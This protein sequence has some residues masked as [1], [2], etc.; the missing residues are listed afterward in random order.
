[1]ELKNSPLHDVCLSGG[2]VLSWRLSVYGGNYPGPNGPG[3]HVTH[4]PDGGGRDASKV[5]ERNE[6]LI[7]GDFSA[8]FEEFHLALAL[9]REDGQAG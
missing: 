2:S 5:A 9:S 6:G 7:G 3:P 4:T 8:C 1:M